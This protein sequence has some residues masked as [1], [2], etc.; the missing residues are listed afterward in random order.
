LLARLVEGDDPRLA[1]ELLQR[2]AMETRR[3]LPG[4]QGLRRTA[5]EILF[6]AQVIAEARKTKE[7]EEKNREQARRER[8][9]AVKRRPPV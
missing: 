7:A 3:A 6:R 4:K 9:E 1:A 2:A 5:G 8:E